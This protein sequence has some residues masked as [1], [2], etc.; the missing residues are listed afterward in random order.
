MK[1]RPRAAAPLRGVR[2]VVVGLGR[3]GGGEGAVRFLASEGAHVTLVDLQGPE[4]LAEPLRRLEASGVRA[5]LRLGGQSLA[6]CADADLVV[7]NPAVKPSDPLALA[8][9]ARG[10]PTT[11]EMALFLER[12]PAPVLAVTGSNGKSTTASL[13]AAILSACGARTHLGGNIGRSLLMD[14]AGIAPEDRVVLEVSSFQA[15]DFARLGVGAAAVVVTNLTPNHLDYHG[16]MA[17]YAGAKR[18]LLETL[19]R[20]GK[21]GWGIVNADDPAFAGWSGRWRRA[22]FSLRTMAPPGAWMEGGRARVV[23]GETDLRLDLPESPRLAGPHNRA[24]AL[25]ALAGAAAVWDRLDGEA[26]AS[27]IRGFPGLPHRLE[28]VAER[29]GVRFYNDSKATTLEA[30]QVAMLAFPAG[31]V[32][33]IAG[34]HNKNVDLAP[35]GALLRERAKAVYLIG[36]AAAEL[37]AFVPEAVQCGTLERAVREAAAA[38][39]TGEV[40]L[41]SPACASFDQ[42]ANYEARGEAFR[43]LAGE[44]S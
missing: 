23:M 32:H 27:A 35:F 21:G 7:L 43:A 17:A 20:E 38:A 22:G 44:T 2:A 40:V 13:A 37:F 8:L 6:D 29:A 5:R 14:L 9:E 19:P 1:R 16:G 10:I 18:A 15:K 42:F 33:I 25:A 39:K 4:A 36:E 31:V 30:A 34:G 12:C 28:L 41:L 3:F 11:S 24:N 26:A